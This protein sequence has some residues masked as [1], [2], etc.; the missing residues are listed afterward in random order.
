MFFIK[1]FGVLL[2][3]TFM[4]GAGVLLFYI[5]NLEKEIAQEKGK[6]TESSGEQ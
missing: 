5:S 2:A 4:I 6:E 3:I 1:F